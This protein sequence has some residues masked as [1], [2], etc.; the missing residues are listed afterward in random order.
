MPADSLTFRPLPVNERDPLRIRKGILV[1]CLFALFTY[2]VS[3]RHSRD[4]PEPFVLVQVGDYRGSGTYIRDD[5]ILSCAHVVHRG[6][7]VTVKLTN[8]ERIAGKVVWVSPRN[9]LSLIQT[10]PQSAVIPVSIAESEYPR[11]G[12]TVALCGFGGSTEL[13]RRE[14]LIIGKTEMATVWANREPTYVA[15]TCLLISGYSQ[16]GDSGGAALLDNRVAG[17]IIGSQQTKEANGDNDYYTICI[18]AVR[19]RSFV[20]E[21]DEHVRSKQAKRVRQ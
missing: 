2:V 6:G 20:A 21:W 5:L 9:E 18:P 7:T 8:G 12:A 13:H 14:G 10:R 3:E 16:P 11:R 1:I 4:R 15:G 17:V 19:I